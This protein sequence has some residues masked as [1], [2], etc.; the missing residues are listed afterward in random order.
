MSYPIS[1][2]QFDNPLLKE[3]LI[4]L[5]TYFTSKG[6]NYYIIGATARDIVF[7]ALHAQGSMRKTFDLD[8]AIAISDWKAFDKISE[9]LCSQGHFEKSK[10]QKQRFRYKGVYELD[11]VPFGEVAKA[12]DKIY[13]PPEED[14]AMSVKGFT[15]IAKETIKLN[16]DEEFDINVASL[17]GIFV[18]KLTAWKDRHYKTGKDADDMSQIIA[19]YY[20]IHL[21]NLDEKYYHIYDDKDFTEYTAGAMILGD[22]L[23]SLLQGKDIIRN[24]V[25]EILEKE[26]AKEED[27]KLVFSALQF[28][29]TLKFDQVKKAFNII[30]EEIKK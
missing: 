20:P 4:E 23:K 17:P 12:D 27:S 15:E 9:D 30:L 26:I 5:N 29:K 7:S 1:S 22:E 13:W 2:K 21:E 25:I 3:L 28:D 24:E 10:D 18:L 8:I 14:H 19:S 6:M 16:V 11:I